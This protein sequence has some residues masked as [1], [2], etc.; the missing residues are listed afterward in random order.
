MWLKKEGDIYPSS[1]NYSTVPTG[2]LIVINILGPSIFTQT[3]H[4]HLTLQE[5]L[6]SS[7]CVHVPATPPSVLSLC[8]SLFSHAAGGWLAQERGIINFLEWQTLDVRRAVLSHPPLG[9]PQPPSL[10]PVILQLCISCFLSPQ[11]AIHR[12]HLMLSQGWMIGYIKGYISNFSTMD[13]LFNC[14]RSCAQF[15]LC[16]FMCMCGGRGRFVYIYVTVQLLNCC[17]SG[18]L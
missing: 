13:V 3:P 15:V 14:L 10:L 9:V 6:T 16:A 2:V 11:T 1:H 5:H 18:P 8:L 12:F 7:D 4:P 17:D